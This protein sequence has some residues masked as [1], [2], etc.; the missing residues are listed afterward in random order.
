MSNV[1]CLTPKSCH[2]E[3]LPLNRAKKKK[4]SKVGGKEE[5]WVHKAHASPFPKNRPNPSLTDLP[6]RKKHDAVFLQ[7]RLQPQFQELHW[8]LPLWP[9]QSWYS[10]N[11]FRAFSLFSSVQDPRPESSIFSN[12]VFLLLDGEP[13]TT[14]FGPPS[15]SN[16]K[17]ARLST[18]MH[19]TDWVEAQSEDPEIK[20]AMDWCC[21]N[22]K[23]SEPWTEQLAKLKTRLGSKKNTPEGK[24]HTAEC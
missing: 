22:K 12:K 15:S 21:L 11:R 6:A 16:V 1:K 5:V 7:Y 2:E 17:S 18:Q 9:Q 19:V 24:E 13:G 8:L 4:E 23:K 20:A 14:F 10:V 3:Q